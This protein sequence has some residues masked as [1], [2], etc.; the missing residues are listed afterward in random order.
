MPEQVEFRGMRR[1]KQQV[2]DDECIEILKAEKRGVL[3][4]AGTD[5]YPYGIPVDFYYEDGVIYIHGAKSGHKVDAITADNRVCFTT[6]NTGFIKPG[7]WAWNVTS[8]IAFGRAELVED[9]D[10]T[11]E[12]AKKLGLKY[13]PTLEEVEV[14]LESGIDRVQLIAL[15]IEHMTGKLVKEK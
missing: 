10:L 9:R 14:E 15:H 12:M 8:V 13:Y 6:W 2:S 11:Y 4:V 3:S 7:D 1:K 5:G